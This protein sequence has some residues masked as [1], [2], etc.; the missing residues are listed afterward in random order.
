MPGER[1]FPDMAC[2]GD[3][4]AVEN[5][6]FYIASNPWRSEEEFD[7][8]GERDVR[9]FFEG[10]EELLAPDRVVLDI[11]C[12]IGRMVRHVAPRI[13]RLIGVDVS[14]EMIERARERL[15]EHANVELPVGDGWTLQPVGA[16][17]VD[18]VYTYIVL[19][20]VPRPV[21]HSHFRDAHRVLRPGGHFLP[22]LPGEPQPVPE[23]PPDE[24]T[25]GLRFYAGDELRRTFEELGYA[26]EGC[27][28]HRVVGDVTS[29]VHLRPR[30]REP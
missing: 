13:G 27:G 1:P 18:L 4:R 5:A 30:L 2:V 11:G 19:Q 23:E 9:L 12:A 10:D 26:R 7:E 25:F 24:D 22:Q 8:S 6:R 21:A 14:A 28:R 15:A 17:S 3:R 20:H 16:D 29:F